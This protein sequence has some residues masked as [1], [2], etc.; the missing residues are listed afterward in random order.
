MSAPI[1]DRYVVSLSC[2]FFVVCHAG[3]PNIVLG[4]TAFAKASILLSRVMYGQHSILCRFLCVACACF[5]WC[6]SDGAELP[7]SDMQVPTYI[8][9][10][11]LPLFRLPL[12]AMVLVACGPFLGLSFETSCEVQKYLLQSIF[13]MLPFRQWR[14]QRPRRL[15]NTIR[16]I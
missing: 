16:P 6:C 3:A 2:Q 1:F 9:F 14:P 15:E 5:M 8:S 4:Q 7:F 11:A 10:S 13:V 12:S